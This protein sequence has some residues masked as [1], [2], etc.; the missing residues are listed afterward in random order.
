MECCKAL[1]VSNDASWLIIWQA[2]DVGYLALQRGAWLTWACLTFAR[3][4]PSC[5][6]TF[7]RVIPTLFKFFVKTFLVY[8]YYCSATWP[9]MPDWQCLIALWQSSEPQADCKASTLEL[10]HESCL[11]S[12]SSHSVALNKATDVGCFTVWVWLK[13]AWLRL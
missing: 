11:E 5:S 2:A 7:A 8:F 1:S 12:I 10:N 13:Q 4:I 6:F 3:V 9:I